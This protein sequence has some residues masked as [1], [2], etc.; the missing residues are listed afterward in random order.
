MTW[1]PVE[2]GHLFQHTFRMTVNDPG[3]ALQTLPLVRAGSDTVSVSIR[4]SPINP[5]DQVNFGVFGSGR[6][7][8][9]VT[10]YVSPHSVHQVVVVTDPVKHL[11]EVS[12][13]G[14][15][16]LSETLVKG[17]PIH[18]EPGSQQ[19][20]GTTPALSVSNE[21]ASTPEPTLCRSLMP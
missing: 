2:L 1:M 3:S 15:L 16:Y 10:V 14:V 6:P 21:T 4:H 18:A 7:L 17:T 19:T 9:G 13:G 12:M 5:Y 8:Y 20:P 11:A